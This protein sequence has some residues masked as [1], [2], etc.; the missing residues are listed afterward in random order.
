MER[1]ILSSLDIGRSRSIS[2]DPAY[3]LEVLRNI[4]IRSINQS[5]ISSIS[6]CVKG[7]FR[8]LFQSM[9]IEQAIGIPFSISKHKNF[10]DDDDGSSFMITVYPREKQLVDLMLS[11]LSNIYDAVKSNI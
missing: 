10:D 2:A 3:G 9:Q 7:L 8:L 1:V 11:E 4:A 5:D 6:A